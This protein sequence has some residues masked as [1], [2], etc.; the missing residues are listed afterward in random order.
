MLERN[1]GN[2]GSKLHQEH[3][4]ICAPTIKYSMFPGV[5]QPSE[6]ILMTPRTQKKNIKI[7][8]LSV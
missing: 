4:E 6:T 7:N 1:R 2:I 5:T 3:F 8:S